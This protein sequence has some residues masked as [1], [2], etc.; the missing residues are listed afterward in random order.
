MKVKLDNWSVGADP[1]NP[2]TPPEGRQMCLAGIIT[3]HPRKADGKDVV[4]S[5][6]VG[7]EDGCIKT[8]SG[9]L[10]ELGEAESQYEALHPNAK[11]RL[12]ASWE[13]VGD[14]ICGQRPNVNLMG[15]GKTLTIR[16]ENPGCKVK[17][18]V[19]GPESETRALWAC[20]ALSVSINAGRES[21]A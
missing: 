5:P 3:G 10:Y 4:T 19:T 9:T 17:P 6:I 1:R 13:A 18:V 8:E 12:L 20:R 16:C 7:V 11:A 15:D 2:W 21:K 14:C